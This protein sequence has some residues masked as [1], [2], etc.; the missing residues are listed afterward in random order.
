[1]TQAQN[2]R[3]IVVCHGDLTAQTIH[4]A[5]QEGT[6]FVVD[7]VLIERRKPIRQI[8]AIANVGEGQEKAQISVVYHMGFESW[9]LCTDFY[10]KQ[11]AIHYNRLSLP[12]AIAEFEVLVG[13]QLPNIKVIEAG[14]GI[15][16]ATNTNPSNNPFALVA[17]KTYSVCDKGSKRLVFKAA[18]KHNRIVL[19]IEDDGAVLDYDPAFLLTLSQW[20]SLREEA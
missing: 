7:E 9:C 6:V 5:G 16:S 20:Q 15:Y 11:K 10:T 12:A 2:L 3:P 1:M 19:L 18:I 17:G 14:I 8:L 4:S 13:V